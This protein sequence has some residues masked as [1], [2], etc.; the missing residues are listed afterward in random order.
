MRGNHD[1]AQQLLAQAKELKTLRAQVQ[2]LEPSLKRLVRPGAGQPGGDTVQ[3]GLSR[4]QTPQPAFRA[5][6]LQALV[7]MGGSGQAHAVLTRVEQLM[8]AQL[9]PVDLEELPS[10]GHPIRWRV[11]A[12]W[13]RNT[14]RREGLLKSGSPNGTWE[15]SDAGREWLRE[16]EEKCGK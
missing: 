12:R 10:N 2:S 3:P 11:S 13:C 4:P 5:P 6:I 8:H 1:E 9:T 7:E 14:M 16:Q 15:I